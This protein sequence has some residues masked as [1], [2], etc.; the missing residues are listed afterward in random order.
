MVQK[1]NG[2]LVNHNDHSFDVDVLNCGSPLNLTMTKAPVIDA[3]SGLI[4]VNFAGTFFDKVEQTTHVQM[5]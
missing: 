3:K 5:P 1:L 4:T 2:L